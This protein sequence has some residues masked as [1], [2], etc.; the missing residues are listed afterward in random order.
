MNLEIERKSVK[1]ALRSARAKAVDA[2]AKAE[3]RKHLFEK[4]LT[5]QET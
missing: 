1:V 4:K 2:R 3:R 5:A